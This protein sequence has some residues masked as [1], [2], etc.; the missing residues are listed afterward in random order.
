MLPINKNFLNKMPPL[1]H[2]SNPPFEALIAECQATPNITD[3]AVAV[4]VTKTWV[5]TAVIGLNLCPFAKA[6][7][8]KKQIRY[9]VSDATNQET[10]ELALENELTFLKTADP[11]DI[12]TTLLIHPYVLQ[13][14]VDYNN[15]LKTAQ[16]ILKQQG[17]R[18]QIQIASFHPQYEFAHCAGD[19]P[20][21][22]TNRSP[23]PMLHLLREKS[24]ETAL[25]AAGDADDIYLR[26]IDTLQTLGVAGWNELWK[27][28]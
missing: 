15:F 23:F 14:F 21:N 10:L 26:N 4:C 5:E 11:E 12:D 9:V 19:A 18:G 16:R 25:N 13:D 17:L 28:T 8:R 7:Y 1:S 3:Q 6:V 2:F 20:E 27:P 24:I 22:Y